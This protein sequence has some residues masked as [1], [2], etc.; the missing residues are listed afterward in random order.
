YSY[1][2]SVLILSLHDA[3]PIYLSKSY[4][5]FNDSLSVSRSKKPFNNDSTILSR[6]S[7]KFLLYNGRSIHFFN[8][9]API[10]VTVLSRIQSK[11]QYF[12]FFNKVSVN[13]RFLF[14]Y[15]S[16]DK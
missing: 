6:L 5:Y 3:L 4:T 12:S 9:R 10:A 11:E 13:S 2:S 15:I 16:N 7:I 8:V 1:P 14:E